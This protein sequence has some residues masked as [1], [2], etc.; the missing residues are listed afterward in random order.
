MDVKIVLAGKISTNKFAEMD[1]VKNDL[2][3]VGQ[4]RK[5]DYKR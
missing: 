3:G 4:E 2:R 1:F 5:M